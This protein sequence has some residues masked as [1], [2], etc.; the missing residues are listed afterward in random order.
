MKNK[1]IERKRNSNH[2]LVENIIADIR[3]EVVRIVNEDSQFSGRFEDNDEYWTELPKKCDNWEIDNVYDADGNEYI[4]Q[5]YSYDYDAKKGTYAKNGYML[6]KSIYPNQG[7]L[8]SEEG[9]NKILGKNSSFEWNKI[10]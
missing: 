1:L 4:L 7:K 2:S 6:A 3:K 10:R 9:V 5:T 8:L